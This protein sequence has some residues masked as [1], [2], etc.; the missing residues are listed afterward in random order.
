[1]TNST[2]NKKDGSKKRVR[3]TTPKGPSSA[4]LK[5]VREYNE[6]VEK[7]NNAKRKKRGGKEV[8]CWASLCA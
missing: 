7:H 2:T 3:N 8:S 4:A 6:E 1:M 5:A